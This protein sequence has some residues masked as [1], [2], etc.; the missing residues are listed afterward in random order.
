MYGSSDVCSSDLQRAECL[1]GD[2]RAGILGDDLFGA[3]GRGDIRPAPHVIAHDRHFVVG[4]AVAQ[5][6]HAQTRV[7]DVA[8]ARIRSEERRVGKECVRTCRCRWSTYKYTKKTK[9]YK[10]Q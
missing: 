6:D 3:L 4:H 9:K 8:A 10:R 2:R 5:I 7:T 1:D